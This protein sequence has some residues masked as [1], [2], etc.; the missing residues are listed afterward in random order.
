[1]SVIKS[2]SVGN[3]DMFYIK[4]NSDNFTLI[5]CNID[6]TNKE[7]LCLKYQKPRCYNKSTQ[8]C[9]SKLANRQTDM[10]SLWCAIL[11]KRLHRQRWW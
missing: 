1:M 2:F 6:E 7:T 8:N 11:P 4:H 10:C 9:A 5:D 3:S